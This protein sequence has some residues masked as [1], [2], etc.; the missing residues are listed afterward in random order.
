[1]SH[2]ANAGIRLSPF[3]RLLRYLTVRPINLEAVMNKHGKLTSILAAAMVMILAAPGGAWAGGGR[4][5]R[6]GHDCGYQQQGHYRNHYNNHYN[7]RYQ[8]G[9]YYRG[10]RYYYPYNCGY[11][12]CKKNN[13]HHHH[14]NDNDELWIGLLG[15]GIVGYTLSNIH[16]GY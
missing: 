13:S 14:N 9:N 12:S 16:S 3:F 5:D 8:G 6:G 15:G 2:P 10:G 7:N 1:M 4:Y 11:K